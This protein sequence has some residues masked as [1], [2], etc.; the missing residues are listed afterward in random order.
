[1]VLRTGGAARVVRLRPVAPTLVAAADLA[2]A[3]AGHLA[4]LAKSDAGQESVTPYRIRIDGSEAPQPVLGTVPG[5]SPV[6]I[7]AA[8]A[9]AL[10]VA[11]VRP[12]RQVDTGVSALQGQVWRPLVQR[13]GDPVYPG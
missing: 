3:D 13:G 11:T 5:G 1:M 2:W 7:A 6:S 4:V 9:Q 12:G 8:P 10:L